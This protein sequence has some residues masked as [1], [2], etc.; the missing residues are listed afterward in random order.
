MRYTKYDDAKRKLE[1]E[2]KG[3]LY[4]QQAHYH[5]YCCKDVTNI[6]KMSRLKATYGNMIKETK[7]CENESPRLTHSSLDNCIVNL[8]LFC[9]EDTGEQVHQVRTDKRNDTLKLATRRQSNERFLIRYNRAFDATAG[10]VKYHRLH[11]GYL[12]EI[13]QGSESLDENNRWKNNASLSI[14]LLYTVSTPLQGGDH[15]FVKSNCRFL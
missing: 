9:Q 2:I 13:N 12:E 5:L 6:G 15:Y 3:R 1:G 4:H 10:D 11:M 8:C 7:Y 14:S